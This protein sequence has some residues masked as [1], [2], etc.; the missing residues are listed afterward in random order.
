[1]PFKIIKNND[2]Y[3]VENIQTHKKYSKNPITKNKAIKQFNILN[4]YFN[5]FLV[6]LVK[7]IEPSS[8]IFL[9]IYV[10]LNIFLFLNQTFCRNENV[11]FIGQYILFKT[12]GFSQ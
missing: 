12:P 3:Y 11:D 10:H 1:M 4:K 5:P 8:F 9:T 7:S 6:V 2:G